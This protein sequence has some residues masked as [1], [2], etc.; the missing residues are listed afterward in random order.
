MFLGAT[1]MQA[2]AH[3][4]VGTCAGLL[5]QALIGRQLA[6]FGAFVDPSRTW[7]RPLFLSF[8][9]LGAALVKTAAGSLSTYGQKRAAFQV[10]NAVR[11]AI[12]DTIVQK[13]Q[14]PAAASASHAAIT[15]RIR[16]VERGV[17]EGVLAGF[18]AFAHL[19]P[20][21]AALILLSSRLALAALGILAPFALVLTGVR[22]YFRSHHARSA[23]LAE[24]L[25]AGVDELIRHLDLWRTYGAAGRVQEALGQAGE[26][27]GRA[28]ARSEAARSALSGA[29]EALAAAALVGVV[30]LVER[31]GLELGDG[32]LVAFAAVFFLM[33]RPLR[34]LGDARAAI[35]R[36]AISLTELEEMHRALAT[37]TD[38]PPSV[39]FEPSRSGTPCTGFPLAK[40]EVEGVGIVRDGP[41]LRAVRLIAEPGTIVA[42]VGPTGSGKTTL[43]RAL[44][45]LE[46]V[47]EGVIRYAGMDLTRAGVG[48]AARPFAWVPQEPAIISGTLEENIALGVRLRKGGSEAHAAKA[49]AQ[50]GARALA[51]RK[52]GTRVRAGG[53]ELSGGERQ[54]VAIARAV[55]TELPVLL[56]DE[57][58]AGLDPQA[59]TRVLE[60]LEALR[61]QRTIVIVTHRPAPLRIADQV[62]DLGACA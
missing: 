50:I 42:I 36:G 4:V 48:P 40:L 62:V 8:V 53:H 41:R 43:L 18:R 47:A 32:S 11:Q 22:R 2:I 27:A 13:G 52:Q 30:A 37:R 3:G 1:L 7:N 54:Q 17:D 9:G 14:P 10:G 35:E 33:Y 55:A 29:N 5:G 45:G 59:E 34:D 57:P 38:E 20:L 25:H 51:E 6:S 28:A 61:G 60:A 56:L 26:S 19:L 39:S 49:L 16:D 12:T 24:D 23:H 58:T 15:V 21:A 31:G 46:S 44:L